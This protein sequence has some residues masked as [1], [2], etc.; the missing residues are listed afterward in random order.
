MRMF[1]I[2]NVDIPLACMY[3]LSLGFRD[4][5]HLLLILLYGR[6]GSILTKSEHFFSSITISY[7]HLNPIKI[8]ISKQCKYINISIKPEVYIYLPPL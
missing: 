1:T 6:P 4:T 5:F 3:L 8:H 7:H 2:P